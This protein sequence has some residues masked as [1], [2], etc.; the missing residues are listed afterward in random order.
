M[1][2]TD[3]IKLKNFCIAKETVTRIKRQPQ[4]GGKSPAI[5]QIRYPEC[6]ELKNSRRTNNPSNK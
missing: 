1:N 2:G 6:K 5:Q 4:N 3:W